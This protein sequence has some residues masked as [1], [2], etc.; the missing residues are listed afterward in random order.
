MRR[1]LLYLL[2]GLALNA[3]VGAACGVRLNLRGGYSH[4]PETHLWR[5]REATT[6]EGVGSIEL[7]VFPFGGVT[8]YD[9][10]ID[11]W[12]PGTNDAQ[13]ISRFF[14]SI[15]D[16]GR[17][18]LYPWGTSVSWP[19]SKLEDCRGAVSSGWPFESMWCQLS[20][21]SP[22]P[23][24]SPP[25]QPTVFG[26]FRISKTGPGGYEHVL[27]LLPIWGGLFAGGL[28]YALAIATL[29]EGPRFAIRR[30][31]RNNRRRRGQC[32]ACAYDLASL[33]ADSPCP[34]C[35]SVRAG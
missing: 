20:A 32:V 7:V 17:K 23:T 27:P 12:F 5:F 33:P 8:R 11:P 15:P 10:R 35:G 34:E 31:R 14:G 25:M 4:F 3:V 13:H 2:A 29:V 22:F 26:A 6:G 1:G 18:H 24:N 21:P 16:W 19:S 30:A 9:T 28:L